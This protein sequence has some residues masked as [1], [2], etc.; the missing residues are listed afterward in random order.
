[1]QHSLDSG[2]R[3]MAAAKATIDQSV[4]SRRKTAIDSA[5]AAGTPCWLSS[6]TVVASFTPI[7]PG[8]E[9]AMPAV[10]ESK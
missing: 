2:S 9:E 3:P 5:T 7:P 8:K 6:S 1:M 10:P 4:I